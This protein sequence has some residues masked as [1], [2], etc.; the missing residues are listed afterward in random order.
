MVVSVRL[1]PNDITPVFLG[2]GDLIF[3]A[4]YICFCGHGIQL[5]TPNYHKYTSSHVLQF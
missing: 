2:G 5:E 3:V 4:K 1:G